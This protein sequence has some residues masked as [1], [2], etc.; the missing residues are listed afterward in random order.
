MA[1]ED[2]TCRLV[3]P[4]VYTTGIKIWIIY[5]AVCT[6]IMLC[7]TLVFLGPWFKGRGFGGKKHRTEYT[8]T[9]AKR[10]YGYL[11]TPSTDE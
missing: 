7:V 9:Y 11:M 4:T 6:P 5:A 1:G 10:F 3:Y 8:F 2:K